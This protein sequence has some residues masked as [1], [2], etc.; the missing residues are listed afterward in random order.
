MSRWL[1]TLQPWGVLLLRLALGAAMIH[2]GWIKVV[3]ANLQHS[4]AL[5]ALDHWSRYVTTLG[6]PYWL[7]YVSAFTELLGG[8]LVVLGLLTRFAAFM[9]TVNM[10]VALVTVN[11]PKGYNA[12]EYTLALIAI[13]VMLIFTGGGALA[14][15][16]R[17][18]LA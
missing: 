3:P 1:D 9:I 11:I 16:R 14:L 18:G 2:H 15:D 6:L 10:L 17:A 8:L 4:Q 7:G 12:S 5:S 13:A